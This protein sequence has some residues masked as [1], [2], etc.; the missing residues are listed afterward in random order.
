MA[1]QVG[2]SPSISYNIHA[3]R[4]THIKQTQHITVL[5]LWLGSP[6]TLHATLGDDLAMFQ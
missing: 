5:Q 3:D 6:L 4:Q 1:V 2:V